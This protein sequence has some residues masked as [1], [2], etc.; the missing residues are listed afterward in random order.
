MYDTD[1]PEGLCAVLQDS[2]RLVLKNL[3]YV[4]C[5]AWHGASCWLRSLRAGRAGLRACVLVSCRAA[6]LQHQ[7]A[8]SG[9][10]HH[11]RLYETQPHLHC[12][13]C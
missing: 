1:E 10:R 4:G 11:G 13:R 9:C 3:E 2:C 5:V 6:C 7:V 8:V 12:S